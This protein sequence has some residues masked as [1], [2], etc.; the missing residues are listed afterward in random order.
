MAKK[1][2]SIIKGFVPQEDSDAPVQNSFSVTT[3]TVEGSM[4]YSVVVGDVSFSGSPTGSLFGSVIVGS[5]IVLEGL[6]SDPQPNIVVGTNIDMSTATAEHNAVFGQNHTISG[7]GCIIGGDG[8]VTGDGILRCILMG[9]NVDASGGS[10]DSN[11]SDSI[12]V[13]RD[14]TIT[15]TASPPSDGNIMVGVGLT[16]DTSTSAMNALFGDQ[17]TVGASCFFNIVGGQGHSLL[18]SSVNNVSGNSNTLSSASGNVVTGSNNTISGYVNINQFGS[19]N[20]VGGA[21]NSIIDS[22]ENLVVGTNNTLQETYRNL[23][24]GSDN[25]IQSGGSNLVGGAFNQLNNSS[26][27]IVGG[28]GAKVP[29]NIDNA[30][31]MGAFK[32][33]SPSTAGQTGTIHYTA[34]TTNNTPTASG[35]LIVAANEIYSF[36]IHILAVVV[37]GTS[38]LGEVA[39]HSGSGTIMNVSGTATMLNPVTVNLDDFNGGMNSTAV[40]VSAGSSNELKITVTGLVSDTI[41]W[42][43]RIDY[44][45]ISW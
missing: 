35:S 5:E 38:P 30:F 18:F 9:N 12:F 39:I 16:L 19:F 21:L 45:K 15:G 26:Y 41:D 27:G 44:E 40:S 4:L 32:R 25:T 24:G 7:Q 11:V 20:F 3:Q 2:A 6:S 33:T 28:V 13:G 36:R 14:L 43:M 42:L 10:P 31:T 37:A 34:R 1:I 29:A 22:I 23:V 17:N 8:N